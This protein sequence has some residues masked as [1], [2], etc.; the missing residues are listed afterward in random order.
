MH[1]VG[2]VPQSVSVLAKHFGGAGDGVDMM[3]LVDRGEGHAA[4]F[5]RSPS[6]R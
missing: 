3:S 5:S 4:T 1:V 6:T 2:D